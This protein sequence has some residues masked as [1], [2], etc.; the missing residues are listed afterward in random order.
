MASK[1]LILLTI[2]KVGIEV[3][4]AMLLLIVIIQVAIKLMSQIKPRLNKIIYLVR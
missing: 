3:K 2:R 1:A 4:K